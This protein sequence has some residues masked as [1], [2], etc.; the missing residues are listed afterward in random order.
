MEMP[1]LADV[2]WIAVIAAVVVNMVVGFVWYS[3]ALFAKE[4]TALVGKTEAELRK[5]ATTG[6][7]GAVI[8]GIIEAVFLSFLVNAMGA[9]TA[10]DGALVGAMVWFGFI[11]PASL[12]TTLFSQ[13]R[14]KLWAINYGYHLVTLVLIGAVLAAWPN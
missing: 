3:N 14:K 2:N 5:D 9:E 13:T 12:V 8:L 1:S 11:L 10:V 7:V 6:Y 4:W